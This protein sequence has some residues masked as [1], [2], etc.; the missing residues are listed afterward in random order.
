MAAAI[1]F[2][3]LRLPAQDASERDD[4]CNLVEASI[5]LLPLALERGDSQLD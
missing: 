3:A 5:A 1:F 2:P 4:L